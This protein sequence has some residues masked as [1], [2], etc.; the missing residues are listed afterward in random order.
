M[1][2]E[3]LLEEADDYVRFI[4]PNFDKAIVGISH[5]DRL[6]YDYELMIKD[7]T[8]QCNCDVEEA[9]EWIEFNTIRSLPYV[10]N[11]PIIITERVYQ[12]DTLED[13]INENS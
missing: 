13:R 6:V 8:E 12:N 7:Y 3:E 9:I 5:D 1:T 11:S 10:E 4:N 2:L